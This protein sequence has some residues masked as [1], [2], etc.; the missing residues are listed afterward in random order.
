[1]KKIAALSIVAVLGVSLL[2]VAAACGGGDTGAKAAATASTASSGNAATTSTVNVDAEAGTAASTDSTAASAES[3]A[4]P[5]NGA[6]AAGSDK[7]FQ[8]HDLLSAEEASA[9]TGKT[10]TLEDGSLF[11]DED[12]GVISERYKYDIGSS[13]IHGLVEV[14]QDGLST[15]DTTA[16]DAFLSTQNMVTSESAPVELGDQAFTA[17]QGQLH[18]LYGG[19]YIVVAF[20][21]D[22]YGTKELNAALNVKLGAKIL[23]NLKAKL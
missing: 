1:V 11:K 19:Y 9:L 17:G 4:A 10:V 3:T 22:E 7:V 20:D 18:M 15:G 13:T 6:S 16:K 21:G 2:I 14:H 23:E 12:T 5:D 8:P